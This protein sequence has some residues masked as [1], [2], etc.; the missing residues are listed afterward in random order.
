MTGQPERILNV[1]VAAQ[2]MLL[3]PGTFCIFHAPVAAPSGAGALGGLPGVR[4]TPSPTDP[5]GAITIRGLDEDG[6]LGLDRGAALV[7]V[8]N[9]PTWIMVTTY[10]DPAHENVRPNLQVARLY[11]PV[12][13][14]AATPAFPAPATTMPQAAARTASPQPSSRTADAD[15]RGIVAHIQRR[16]DVHVAC[17]AWMGTIGSR[18]WIEGFAILPDAPLAPEQIEYQAVLGQGWFSPWVT[19]GTYCGSRG[20]ALPLLGLRVRLIGQAAEAFTCRVS[21]TFVD[22]SR[23]GP[24]EDI[25]A[26]SDDLSPLEA[27]LI[28]IA[29]RDT[30][31]DG[32][33]EGAWPD[34]DPMREAQVL[35]LLEAAEAEKPAPTRTR[36]ARRTARRG[37]VRPDMAAHASTAAEPPDTDTTRTGRASPRKGRADGSAKAAAKTATATTGKAAAKS[38]AKATGK[39]TAAP[40][41]EETTPLSPEDIHPGRG[42]KVPGSR[43]ALLKARKKAATRRRS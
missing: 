29:P 17:D 15:E 36:P 5:D 42:R 4:V 12:A 8:D 2:L 28:E 39:A 18:A 7:R 3:E 6:W 35:E 21:A 30:L 38:T 24:V 43:V 13:K 25:A 20:M 1:G 19:G 26:M 40:R 34:A 33:A 10:H 37:R 31:R 11:T 14:A 22:G 27:F 16:G 9:R 41:T 23:I 32:A